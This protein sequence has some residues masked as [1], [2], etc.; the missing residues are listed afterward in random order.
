[1]IIVNIK[2]GLGNQMFQY[3]TGKSLSIRKNT[4]LVINKK[5][6]NLDDNVYQLDK[7]KIN[8]EYLE[9]ESIENITKPDE[10]YKVLLNILIKYI[11]NNK[12]LLYFMRMI[13]K[14][15]MKFLPDSEAYYNPKHYFKE[16][17]EK[18][19][20]TNYKEEL[21]DVS[22]PCVIEGYF[23]SYKYFKDIEE[24]IKK[25]FSELSVE[26]SFIG[27]NILEQIENSNSVSIHFRRGDAVDNNEVARWYEGIVTNN[28]YRNSVNYMVK[29]IG[30]PHFFI[31]SNDM[32]YVKENFRNITKLDS[33]INIT[34]VEHNDSSTGYEDLF[35]MSKC[36]H[37][38]TTGASSFAWWAA[39]LNNNSSKIVLRTKEV[40]GN[41]RYNFPSD[42]YPISWIVVDS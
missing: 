6:H 23:P 13:K 24:N 41:P 19:W 9:K 14:Y 29:K 30:N 36:K 7:F 40:N 27:E 2:G 10:N 5:K 3:A 39:F 37:N 11:K 32:S 21:F 20:T 16:H 18:E 33:S 38:I 12:I 31:F 35:L 42:Y 28:Y 1:M 26:L 34:F 25:D 15:F 8:L 4:R 22:I 17:K